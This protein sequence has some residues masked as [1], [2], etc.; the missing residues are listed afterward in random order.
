MLTIGDAVFVNGER[1]ECSQP[2][3]LKALARRQT[4]NLEDF[5]EALDDP[6]LLAQLAALV[7]AGYWYFGDA[8]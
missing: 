2:E 1:V 7:N 5:G 6:S 4:L 8:E 3:V